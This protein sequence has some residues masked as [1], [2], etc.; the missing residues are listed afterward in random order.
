MKDLADEIVKYKELK[1]K[2][3]LGHIRCVVKKRVFF[4]TYIEIM[5]C[6]VD[7]E[8][9]NRARFLGHDFRS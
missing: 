4:S 7:E 3:A 1:E 8:N 9:V 2:W 6:Y 5:G